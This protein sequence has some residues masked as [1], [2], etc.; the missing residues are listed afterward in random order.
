MAPAQLLPP[1]QVPAPYLERLL[2]FLGGELEATRHLHSLM[3]WVQH[4]LLSHGQQ[5]RERP[6]A[7]E[8]PRTRLKVAQHLH[9][10]T[11]PWPT[12]STPANLEAWGAPAQPGLEA[13][14]GASKPAICRPQT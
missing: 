5:L 14:C 3:L 1:W 7:F 6:A 11:A 4:L 12:L 10:D 9:E 13:S 2:R 8:A